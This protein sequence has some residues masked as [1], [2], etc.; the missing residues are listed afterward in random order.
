MCRKATWIIISTHEVSADN[1]CSGGDGAAAVC[2]V[3][4]PRGAQLPPSS[5][6]L[7]AADEHQL[8]ELLAAH[9]ADFTLCVVPPDR[10]PEVCWT[11]DCLRH[12]LARRRSDCACCLIRH[13]S[14]VSTICCVRSCQLR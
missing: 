6:S 5:D 11:I 10:V 7:V 4:D 1:I 9:D 3:C 8:M 14:R 13:V 12:T 2:I